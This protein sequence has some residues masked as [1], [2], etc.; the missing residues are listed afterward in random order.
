MAA[1]S[2]A[3]YIVCGLTG[4]L[5]LYYAARD[6]KADLVLL[7]ACALSLL[8]WAVEFAALGLRDLAGTD[9]FEA[10][11]LY[12]YLLTGLVLPLGGGWVGV[13]E[14]SRWGSLVVGLVALTM[15]ALQMRLPQIW[16]GG[17][18]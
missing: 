16:P 13:W 15:M 6:L 17:F 9:S 4:A 18:A 8:V 12:G 11:T 10:I 2:I 7:G 5:G 14:H 1:L 3:V